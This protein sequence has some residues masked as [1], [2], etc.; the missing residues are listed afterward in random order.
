[1]GGLLA[2]GGQ[3]KS[4][5]P[6]PLQAQQPFIQEAH[7]EHGLQH[8]PQVRR[9]DLGLAL[10]VDDAPFVVEDSIERKLQGSAA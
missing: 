6:L 7:L 4:Y 5:P 8:A 9:R 10:R 1:M 2:G 3:V